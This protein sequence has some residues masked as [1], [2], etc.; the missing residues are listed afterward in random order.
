MRTSLFTVIADIE[1]RGFWGA[2]HCMHVIIP[3]T[4][5]QLHF[6]DHQRPGYHRLQTDGVALLRAADK[7]IGHNFLSY[8][9]RCLN[10]HCGLEL[11]RERVHDTLIA[12]RLAF[13]DLHDDDIAQGKL[14][15][16]LVG[17]HSLEAWGYRLNL[18]TSDF[19]K[20]ADWRV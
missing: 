13:P 16:K 7:V 14:T 11:L 12:S 17:S 1:T 20:T 3:E 15:G 9:L 2:P 18:H 5:D 4:R 8:D 19:G 6:L 10:K